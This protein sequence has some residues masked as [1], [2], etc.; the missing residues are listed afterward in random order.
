MVSRVV[1][2]LFVFLSFFVGHAQNSHLIDGR[3]RGVHGEA[4]KV[5]IE[6]GR[7]GKK[8]KSDS[9]GFFS[10]AV[11]E[12]DML[13]FSA[14]GLEPKIY[15]IT[16]TDLEKGSISVYLSKPNE[17]LEEIVISKKLFSDDAFG[18]GIKKYTPAQRK[19]RSASTSL[20][21]VT[22]GEPTKIGLDPIFNIFNGKKKR[23]KKAMAYETQEL[24]SE[25]FYE[26]YPK[27]DLINR[28]NIPEEH[29]ASFVYF[30]VIQEDFNQVNLERSSA[31]DLFLA[32]LYE[33]YLSLL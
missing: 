33:R 25:A 29:V 8:L 10:I 15:T 18:I 22:E 24:A 12:G 1:Y 28:F 7:S 13:N 14:S 26:F 27:E 23:L 16:K 31:Y 21:R 4:E 11:Q 5:Q 19:Y 9:T 30:A 32:V 6:N 20:F 3:V 17:S 2:L